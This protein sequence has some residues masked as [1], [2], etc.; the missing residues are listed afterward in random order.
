[1]IL[2]FIYFH[3]LRNVD[4]YCIHVFQ[5]IESH[6]VFSMEQGKKLRLGTYLAPGIPLQLFQVKSSNICR[7]LSGFEPVTQRSEVQHS[8][9]RLL[10]TPVV[11]S[12]IFERAN[13]HV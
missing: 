6:P 1:M 8:I 9:S 2:V 4:M 11:N 13:G 12:G 7:N 5:I 10:H 3:F